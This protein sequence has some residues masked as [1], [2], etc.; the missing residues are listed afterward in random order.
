MS[1]TSLLLSVMGLC[2]WGDADF[3]FHSSEYLLEHEFQRSKCRHPSLT[4]YP[5][6][7]HRAHKIS[8]NPTRPRSAHVPDHRTPRSS[9]SPGASHAVVVPVPLGTM[10]QDPDHTLDYIPSPKLDS[11]LVNPP[12]TIH[13]F[14]TE[15]C[16]T[17]TNH[18]DLHDLALASAIPISK[19]DKAITDNQEI[20]VIVSTR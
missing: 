2:S 8:Y 15:V 5:F 4:H 12:Q 1:L 18:S 9:S 14:L 10:P 19:V 20:L 3:D 6:P 17:I 7:R 11:C 16:D 13:S